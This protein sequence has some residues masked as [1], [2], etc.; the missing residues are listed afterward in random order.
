MIASP[1]LPPPTDYGYFIEEETGMLKPVMMTQS[2]AAPELLN[3]LVCMCESDCGETCTCVLN[4]QSCT[5]ACAC[6]AA[7]AMV[8]STKFCTNVQTIL[9]VS[10]DYNDSDAEND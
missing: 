7:L 1:Q 3:D 4:D 6:E 10:L 8:D 5:R 9:A 2:P